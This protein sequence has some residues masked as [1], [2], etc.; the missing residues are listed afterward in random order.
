MLDTSL[1][2]PGIRAVRRRKASTS[3]PHVARH[4]DL[5]AVDQ[6]NVLDDR[7]SEPGAAETSR[8]RLVDPVEA[9]EDALLFLGVD[10]DAGPLPVPNPKTPLSS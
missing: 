5:A 8:T 9:F 1:A 2:S 10:S 7:E 3:G 6:A 4:V